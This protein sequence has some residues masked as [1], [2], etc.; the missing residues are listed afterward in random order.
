MTT[1]D[2]Q[3]KTLSQPEDQ[4]DW[5]FY[6]LVV[7]IAIYIL[8][9]TVQW[10]VEKNIDI[11]VL[12]QNQAIQSISSPKDVV[13]NDA[14]QLTAN[15]LLDTIHFPEGEYLYHHNIGYTEFKKDF[16]LKAQTLMKVKQTAQFL[17]SIRSDDGF[18][19][20]IDGQEICKHSNGRPMGES[21]CTAQLSQGEHLYELFYYQGFGYLGLEARYEQDKTPQQTDMSQRDNINMKFIGRNSDGVSFY[22]VP[23]AK[24]YVNQ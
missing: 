24:R 3:N 7:L 12:Q 14:T 5:F 9:K 11:Q 4:S 19:L 6:F 22:P 10:P 15:F 23:T 20:A 1:E 21:L 2:S 13:Q 8:I 17:F 18:I 16:Y